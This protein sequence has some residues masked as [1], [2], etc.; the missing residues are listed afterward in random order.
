MC[1]YPHTV[2]ADRDTAGMH[3]QP[4]GYSIYIIEENTLFILQSCGKQ[5]T[6]KNDI[7]IDI[8]FVKSHRTYGNK[9]TPHWSEMFLKLI[10]YYRKP[11]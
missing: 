8:I 6:G 4:E 5:K 1:R 7:S 11:L 2:G 10:L 9:T 3:I